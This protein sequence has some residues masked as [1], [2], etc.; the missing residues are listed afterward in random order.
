MNQLQ[1]LPEMLDQ[2]DARLGTLTPAQMHNAMLNIDRISRCFGPAWTEFR[3]GHV[4][5]HNEW[6]Y[7]DC[8]KEQ[9]AAFVAAKR[10]MCNEHAY[11]VK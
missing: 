7:D 6:E 9:L 2:V 11:A 4:V 10:K 5:N 3:T 8:T 1:K